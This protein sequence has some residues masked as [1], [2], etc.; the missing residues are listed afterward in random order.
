MNAIFHLHPLATP[1]P[2]KT[3]TKNIP[4]R[5]Y[6]LTIWSWQ[7]PSPSSSRLA[8]RA[9]PHPASSGTAVS[10]ARIP[11]SN[12]ARKSRPAC[13][14]PAVVWCAAI[15]PP[16]ELVAPPFW[17]TRDQHPPPPPPQTPSLDHLRVG[18]PAE[19]T[20]SRRHRGRPPLT[21]RL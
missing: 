2:T 17:A 13:D 8:H 4:S 10:V 9:L 19:R 11:R 18:P 20:N 15:W 6:Q 7:K 16:D 14:V 1:P 12:V 3:Q 21:H 5:G